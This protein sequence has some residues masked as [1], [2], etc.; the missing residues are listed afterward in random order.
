[1][2][3]HLPLSAEAQAEARILMLSSNNILKP[4]DGRPVTMPTQDMIIGLYHLTTGSDGRQGRGP[5]V[6]ARRPRPAWRSTPASSSSLA[7]QDPPRP[8]R[9]AARLRSCPRASSRR[10]GYAAELLVE[11]TLGRALFNETL[12]VDYP[13][14]NDVVDKKRLS[15]IVNDL[16]ER[17]PK[18]QVAAS[19]DAL[20]EAGFHWATR[21]GVTVAISDV[22]TPPPSRRSSRA[23]RTKAAKVQTQYERGL[24]TD[25]ERRQE[26][27]EIWTQA[28]NEVAKE[29]EAN[30]P[31]TNPIYRMVSSGARGNWMQMRQI[32][33]MRGLVAN[34]K[35]EII[36]R[37]IKCELP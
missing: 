31:R 5:R 19:L 3:V 22:V 32:A 7:G 11:T 26:L 13:F 4:A 34:P 15:T 1:M 37:P 30:F 16:A 28:T 8:R 27:I 20:K 6:L 17:Y 18:V 12:P 9:A 21:S 2:A 33:G 23:T 29:M 36:P 10:E 14:V 35:G 24:I 25:D